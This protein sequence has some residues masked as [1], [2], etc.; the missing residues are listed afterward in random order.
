M[1]KS[2]FIL[3]AIT[4]VS[5]SSC[6]KQRVCECTDTDGNVS[7]STVVGSKSGAGASCDA[8]EYAGTTCELG[9]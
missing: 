5:L 7:K 6:F 3:G 2:I 8:Q 9:K 4:I 1:K